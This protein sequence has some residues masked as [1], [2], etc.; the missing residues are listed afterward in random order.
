MA[1]AGAHEESGDGRLRKAGLECARSWRKCTF[2]NGPTQCGSPWHD[3]HEGFPLA[4]R[5]RTQIVND[6]GGSER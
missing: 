2:Q 4:E 6:T 5:Q 3:L 1:E